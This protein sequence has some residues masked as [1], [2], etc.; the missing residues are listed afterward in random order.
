[1]KKSLGILIVIVIFGLAFL[2]LSPNMKKM[3]E[4]TA[5]KNLV[6]SAKTYVDDIRNIWNSA[7]I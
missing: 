6:T 5:K 2:L 4:S 7:A 3:K 1:M